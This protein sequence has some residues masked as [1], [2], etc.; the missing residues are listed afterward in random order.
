MRML[1]DVLRSVVRLV[2]ELDGRAALG[3]TALVA[4]CAYDPEGF[5][6]LEGRR[7]LSDLSSS[8]SELVCDW[9]DAQAVARTPAAPSNALRCGRAPRA[10][11]FLDFAH[12]CP[13]AREDH[14]PATM[15]QVRR[16][17][18]AVL[19]MIARQPCTFMDVDSYDALDALVR[20]IAECRGVAR[21]AYHPPLLDDE[22]VVQ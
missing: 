7:R 8:E 13:Y 3:L 20:P 4:S 16:C 11:S 15:L 22:V 9:V 1:R 5:D 12:R 10:L 14:C 21:C 6:A 17:I 18:P 2:V 19:A